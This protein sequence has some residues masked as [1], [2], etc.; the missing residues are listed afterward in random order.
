MGHVASMEVV[1]N[2]YRIVVRILSVEITLEI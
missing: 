1:R 2:A